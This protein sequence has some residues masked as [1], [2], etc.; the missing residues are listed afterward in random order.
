MTVRELLVLKHAAFSSVTETLRC[1]PIRLVRNVYVRGA[2]GAAVTFAVQGTVA[3]FAN[4]FAAQYAP[5]E[6]GGYLD[7]IGLAAICQGT[8][9]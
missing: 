7:L 3:W 9:F 1:K 5:A 8:T 6:P 2:A 4:G